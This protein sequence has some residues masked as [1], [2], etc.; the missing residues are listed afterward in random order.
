MF[1]QP[2]ILSQRLTIGNNIKLTPMLIQS[3]TNMK[4]DNKKM[5]KKQVIE[6][7]LEY[8]K[9]KKVSEKALST[10]NKINAKINSNEDKEIFKWLKTG[11]KS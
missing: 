11:W 9:L 4:Q 6:K 7:L 1:K 2:I 5:E 3:I 10:R 8:T